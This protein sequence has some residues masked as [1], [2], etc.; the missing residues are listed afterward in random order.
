MAEIE[1]VSGIVFGPMLPIILGEE[2]IYV[3]ESIR[4]DNVRYKLVTVFL[5]DVI[6]PFNI[7]FIY[8]IYKSVHGFDGRRT[9]YWNLNEALKVKNIIFV[10]RGMYE[11]DTGSAGERLQSEQAQAG[12][13]PD[14]NQTGRHA[15][16]MGWRSHS[17]PSG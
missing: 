12:N 8:H 2:T 4:F 7:D 15:G 10:N 5:Q 9:G 11:E 13:P 3:A 17:R 16:P 6:K 14:V 1:R